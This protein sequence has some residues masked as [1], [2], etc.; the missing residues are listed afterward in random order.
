MIVKAV[1]NIQMY[2]EV[3]PAL[4]I[5]PEKCSYDFPKLEPIIEEYSKGFDILPK[6][7]SF[8]L[9]ILL[10]FASYFLLYK[11]SA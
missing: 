8:L 2:R 10:S 4:V 5:T 6:K 11:H 9:P 7:V 1:K 3:A